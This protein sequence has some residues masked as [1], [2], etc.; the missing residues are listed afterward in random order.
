MVRGTSL[1]L[2]DNSP[3]ESGKMHHWDSLG[4]SATVVA[5]STFYKRTGLQYFP[6][7]YHPAE[8]PLEQ[9]LPC[10]CCSLAYLVLCCFSSSALV[11][12][13]SSASS[14]PVADTLS[15]A[16]VSQT[17]SL[18]LSAALWTPL[19][20]VLVFWPPVSWHALQ[21][22]PAMRPCFPVWEDAEG[23]PLCLLC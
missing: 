1:L 23:F 22:S 11:A 12:L 20:S 14:A 19:A 9:L 10:F 8:S 21:A 15:Q 2:G 6:G 18:P 16:P 13:S 7:S 17:L 5:P 4:W 3:L